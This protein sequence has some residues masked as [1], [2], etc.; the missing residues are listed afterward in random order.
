MK[1]RDL[2]HNVSGRVKDPHEPLTST[3]D[4]HEHSR[5]GIPNYFQIKTP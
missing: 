2:Q 1:V 4:P 5:P 3:P